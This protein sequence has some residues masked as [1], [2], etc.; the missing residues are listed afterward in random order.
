MAPV[1]PKDDTPRL[2]Q[3]V[4]DRVGFDPRRF[5]LPASLTLA[6]AGFEGLSV[7]L[8]IPAVQGSI[9]L[10]FDFLREH[11]VIVLC[12]KLFPSLSSASSHRLFV[13]LL[14]VI[15]AASLLKIGLGYLGAYRTA[16]LGREFAEKLRRLLFDRLLGYG[17]LYFDQASSSHLQQ[18]L[19]GHTEAV[20]SHFSLFQDI[21]LSF[22][23]ALVYFAVMLRISAKLTLAVLLVFP[24]MHYAARILSSSIKT[25]SK[26]HGETRK[27]LGT[28]LTGVL[29]NI[30]LVKASANEAAE[31]RGFDALSREMGGLEFAIGAR[32]ALVRPVQELIFLAT[33]VV[34]LFIMAFQVGN[35]RSGLIPSLFVFVY[36]MRRT[37]TAVNMLSRFNTA[38]AA[39][40]A[41]IADILG[42]LEAAPGAAVPDGTLEFPGLRERIEIRQLSFRFPNG[43]QA[44]DGASF[45]IE[46][47]KMTAIV[48]PSGTGKT[49]LINLLLRLYDPPPGSILLDGKDLREF[50]ID[51]LR[52][53]TALIGQDTPLFNASIRENIAYPRD[54]AVS[55][56]ELA[57]C[58]ERAR[59]GDLVAK[60]PEGLDSVVGERGVKLS[61]G[62]KQRLAI[63]RAILRDA[64]LVL[65]DEATSALDSE[66]EALIQGSIE[67]AVKGR[68]AVVV[69]HRLSTIKNADKIVVLEGGRVV[70]E[71]SRR[72]LLE[73]KGR[74]HDYWEA[75]KFD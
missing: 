61:G 34:F 11:R 10:S 58:V 40:H 12:Q 8:L 4:F 9:R 55:E 5:L 3:S 24:A 45:T 65:L 71:G 2:L 22:F 42:V 1:S 20:V 62:E 36:V 26:D 48:G 30:S 32:S 57:A 67:S 17:K 53:K 59:L 31:S 23:L 68:T 28:R 49:T 18:T 35:Q 41:P 70:E 73:R 38:L 7:Y 16:V 15:S 52:A 66:T 43:L 13:V 44:L 19:I 56:K 64:E 21:L 47:G 72:E 6:A 33:L 25:S 75:Q 60:L 46:K 63:A 54:G 50:K 69:A 39:L 27:R 74:F 29:S 14:L 37:S 51:G